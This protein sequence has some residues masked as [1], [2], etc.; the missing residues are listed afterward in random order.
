M[1]ISPIIVLN[2]TEYFISTRPV[3]DKIGRM[4]PGFKLNTL[5]MALWLLGA[6]LLLEQ[7]V[8]FVLLWI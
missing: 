2:N 8:V 1:A 7:G 3:Q 6:V 4:A 5:A